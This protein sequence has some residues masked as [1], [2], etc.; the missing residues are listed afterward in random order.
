[1]QPGVDLCRFGAARIWPSP[2]SHSALVDPFGKPGWHAAVCAAARPRPAIGMVRAAT[3]G[4]AEEPSPCPPHG[5]TFQPDIHRDFFPAFNQTTPNLSFRA[6]TSRLSHTRQPGLASGRLGPFIHTIS[7]S[8]VDWAPACTTISKQPSKACYRD[9][10]SQSRPR[11][12]PSCNRL[13]RIFPTRA[14]PARKVKLFFGILFFS[15]FLSRV[16]SDGQ[17]DRVTQDTSHTEFRICHRHRGNTHI[18]TPLVY[19]ASDLLTGHFL[20]FFHK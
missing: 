8:L 5:Y 18:I 14:V 1:V 11:M 16:H 6:F 15:F 12:Q 3:C 20:S 4:G 7:L 2:I 19:Q 17:G 13:S 9:H 10:N